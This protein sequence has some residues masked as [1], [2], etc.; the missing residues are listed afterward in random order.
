MQ[1]DM[2]YYGTYAIAAAAG[3]PKEDA[4]VIAHAAQYVDDQDSA[5]L[6]QVR[7]VGNDFCEG[8]IGTPTAHHPI[9]AGIRTEVQAGIDYVKAH[10]RMASNML[11][12]DDSR[13]VWVPFHFIPGNKGK[14]FHEKLICR[15]DSKIANEMV[16]AHLSRAHEDFGLELMGIAA[17]VYLDTF[18]HFGFSGI[19]SFQNIVDIDSI[20]ISPKHGQKIRDYI[21]EK[22]V[23][24]KRFH[25]LIEN[26]AHLGHG[27][28]DTCPDRPFLN[29]EFKYQQDGK[30][31]KRDNF[32][33]FVEACEKLYIY[34]SQFRE[35]RY[36]PGAASPLVAYESIKGKVAS[37]LRYEGTGDERADQWMLA[38]ENRELG[39][40]QPCER[41]D[42]LTWT[43]DLRAALTEKNFTTI[44]NSN[45]YQF[46]SAADHHRHFVLKIL[47]PKH[48]IIVA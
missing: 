21:E 46:H 30:L 1:Y 37:I 27:G 19:K 22:S 42:P 5:I 6:E 44:R 48:G 9:E 43:T 12:A 16:I 31:E 7:Q 20:K 33:N 41:Y 28:V 26:S 17:H 4:Q 47:L 40:V 14:T 29:W 35:A 11:G 18:A 15:K 8:V 38:M 2:H 36:A 3:I 23:T 25:A 34:F 10:I 39:S 24:F 45:A 32:P 13:L